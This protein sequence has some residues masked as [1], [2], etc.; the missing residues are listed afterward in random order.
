MIWAL[1]YIAIGIWVWITTAKLIWLH[2]AREFP[3]LD[4]DDETIIFGLALG[5]AAAIVWPLT[6]VLGLVWG[7]LW[8]TARRT[9]ERIREE[10]RR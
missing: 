6:V 4:V 8:P 7:V 3:M 5:F 9:A 10:E 2:D 1:V